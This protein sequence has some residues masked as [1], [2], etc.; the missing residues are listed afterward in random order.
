MEEFVKVCSFLLLLQLSCVAGFSSGPPA[1]VCSS[2]LPNHPS[3]TS[4]MDG[5]GGY[6]ITATIPG[7]AA[8]TGY[9]YEANRDYTS[10]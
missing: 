9:E 8:G 3:T 10:E 4:P 5:N 1:S 2:L 6:L 7:N